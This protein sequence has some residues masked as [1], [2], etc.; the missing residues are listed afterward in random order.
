MTRIAWLGV[1]LSVSI[2]V[3]FCKSRESSLKEDPILEN[4]D[5]SEVKVLSLT[6]TTKQSESFIFIDYTITPNGEGDA[7][8]VVRTYENLKKDNLEIM[9]TSQELNELVQAEY[10]TEP[11]SEARK[12]FIYKL[13]NGKLIDELIFKQA[14]KTATQV[15]LTVKYMKS[16]GE[17][18]EL[19]VDALTIDPVIKNSLSTFEQLVIKKIN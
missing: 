9:I 10:A 1:T 15:M 8:V 16:S 5:D 4:P 17:M 18:N 14:S 2:L 6:Q 19:N 7:K 11:D 3:G 13:F 12:T